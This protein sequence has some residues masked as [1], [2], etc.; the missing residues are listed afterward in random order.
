MP[1]PISLL[2]E[3]KKGGFEASLITTYNAYLPFYEAVVLRRLIT[4]GVRHNILLMDAG[5]CGQA[6]NHHPPRLAGRHY[7]LVPMRANGAFHPKVLLLVGKKKGALFIG[8]HKLTLSGFG[9]N[10]EVTNC[11]RFSGSDYDSEN[12]TCIASA[13][14]QINGWVKGQAHLPAH[15]R[16][17]IRKLEGF[18][19]WLKSP[20]QE[21]G[22]VTVISCQP[23]RP[24]LLRQLQEHIAGEVERIIV[25][26][27]FFDQKELLFLETLQ[28]K[29]HPR[30]MVI[31]VDPET[32]EIPEQAQRFQGARFINCAG[33]AVKKD[34]ERGGYLHAK[35]ILVQQADGKTVLACGSANP[36]AA[37]WLGK[38]VTRNI[39]MMMCRRDENAHQAALDMGL[40]DIT[41]MPELTVADWTTATKNRSIEV[42]EGERTNGTIGV[43]VASENGIVFQ[44]L[45]KNWPNNLQ[46]DLLGQEKEV[47]QSG[48]AATR[49]GKL[50]K[51]EGSRASQEEVS[52][53]LCRLKHKQVLYL[54]HHERIL[55]E[56]SRT[57]IQRRLRDAL[58]S[59]PGD[60]PDI[61]T[62]IKCI[63]KIIFSKARSV[64]SSKGSTGA[65]QD[66]ATKDNDR[67][68]EGSPL[69]IDLSE[70]K[71]SKKKYRLRYSEDL[72]F[73]FDTLLYHLNVDLPGSAPRGQDVKGRSEEE[74]VGADDEDNNDAREKDGQKY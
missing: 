10:R 68:D 28:Q 30:E 40:Y 29:F 32:V 42:Q 47:L 72:G 74:Q 62:C 63:D 9:Y 1:E 48:M 56:Q 58:T 25:I 54:V 51:V 34:K 67:E 65:I 6:V 37:A 23:D 71:K 61:E 66:S 41:G 19:P 43:A 52:W 8:S 50:F 31:G 70:T 21:L 39:E 27:A 2:N 35:A 13:W 69:S 18:A 11:V 26:G 20:G 7:S 59:L 44:E 3:I 45:D 24:E 73:V 17:M 4:S 16:K 46:C 5:Q 22:A 38:G 12:R 36:S 53:L 60:S 14:E 55:A 57:G 64:D 33:L 15:V 49:S